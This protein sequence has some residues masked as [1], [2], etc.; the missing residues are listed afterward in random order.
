MLGPEMQGDGDHGMVLFSALVA[1]RRKKPWKG[2][3][4]SGRKHLSFSLTEVLF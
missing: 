2:K 3:R 4:L 1:K